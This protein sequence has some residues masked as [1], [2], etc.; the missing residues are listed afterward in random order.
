MTSILVVAPSWVGDAVLAQPL[1]ARLHERHA[2]LIDID[3]PPHEGTGTVMR[4]S[5]P[6][7]AR[8]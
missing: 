7:K 2:G 4:V 3:T 1:F 6:L 8:D 5:L